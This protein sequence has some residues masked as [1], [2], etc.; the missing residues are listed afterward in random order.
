MME[1]RLYNGR[2]DCIAIV[3]KGERGFLRNENC[4]IRKNV[5]DT[6]LH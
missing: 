3:R 2:V 4:D 6:S 1:V 5:K